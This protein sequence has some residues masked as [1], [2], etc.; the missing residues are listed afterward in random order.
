MS[1]RLVIADEQAAE[2][3]AS[4]PTVP[5]FARRATDR[6]ERLESQVERLE[7]INATLIA[8]VEL[9]EAK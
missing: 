6:I 8:R 2:A 3:L 9:L 1:D 4:M 7:R 5:P